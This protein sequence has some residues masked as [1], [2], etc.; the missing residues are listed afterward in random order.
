MATRVSRRTLLQSGGAAL[1]LS[2]IAAPRIA[3]AETATLKITTWGGKWGEVMKGE[4]LP[5]FYDRDERGI[6]LRWI[7]LMRNSLRTLGPR[8]CATR[9]VAQYVAGPYRTGG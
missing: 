4:V 7:E 2:A 3:R 6:P 1:A 9:M 5:A 8:F